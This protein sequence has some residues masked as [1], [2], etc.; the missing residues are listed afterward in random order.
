MVFKKIISF[1]LTAALTAVLAFNMKANDDLGS[2]QEYKWHISGRV[3]DEKGEPL[4]GT[5]VSIL[6]TTI[7]VG[8]NSEGYFDLKT[9]LSG[10]V[11]L[12]VQFI[13]YKTKEKKVVVGSNKSVKIAL[14]PSEN[15][16]DQVV[17]TGVRR[18]RPLKETPVLTR[19]ISEVDIKKIAPQNFETLLQYEL[20][21]LQISYNSMSQ[22]PEINYKGMG[23]DYIVFLVDGE[24]VSGEGAARNVDFSRFNVD[25]IERIEVVQGAASTLYDSN[26]LGGVVNIITKDANRPVTAVIS[27]RYAGNNGEKYSVCAGSKKSDFSTYTTFGY[28]HRGNYEIGDKEGQKHIVIH[29]DGTQEEKQ[30][31]AYSTKI[32]GYDIFDASQK[33]RYNV[34]EKLLT[35]VKGSVYRNKR[36]VRDGKRFYNVYWN[37]ALSAKVGYMFNKKNKIDYT[38]VY[39]SYDKVQNYTKINK[40][41]KNYRNRRGTSRLNYS[42]QFGKHAVSAG[43]EFKY[44]SLKHYMTDSSKCRMKHFDVF[45]Q[46]EF[47]INKDLKLVAG[48]RG[49]KARGYSLHFTPK[50]S[51]KYTLKDVT[52]RAGYAEGYRIPSLKELYTRYDMGGLGMFTI[53][54]NKNLK[55]EKSS[56]YTFSTEYSKG[57][58]NVS[59]SV[60]RNNFRRKIELVQ[61]TG[62]DATDGTSDNASEGSSENNL[63][64]SSQVGTHEK[65]QNGDLVYVNTNNARSTGFET[66]L[67][68]K[69]K[70]GFSLMGSYAYVNDHSEYN[71]KNVSYVRPHSVTFSTTYARDVHKTNLSLTLNG[72]WSSSL[73]TYG[74]NEDKSMTMYKYDSRTMCS[75]NLTARFPRGITAGF[76]IDNLLDY[77]D[78]SS[79]APLQV[80]TKGRTYVATLSIN[81]ADLFNL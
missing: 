32:Y 27:G 19:V 66:I 49:D 58:F 35:E 62:S 44:E 67:R 45:T 14:S 30:E 68:Y 47:L 3:V 18:E 21:G 15:F 29:P 57:L 79:S 31:E 1:T 65:P 54:G 81:I 12:A 53:F 28:R 36:A 78:K 9:R 50:L 16:I 71:G 73:K 11:T 20:P 51:L 43:A 59:V 2:E 70:S 60:Y 26:A 76:I 46:D 34:T 23:G 39:D 5:S 52:F 17:V 42:G 56:Q 8:T 24:R 80:P 7:G 33:F 13:G 75:L 6:G 48:I 37:Y 10:E 63:D 55:P 74:F 25:N 40:K 72:M 22:A 41:T 77:R 69:T 61:Y 64:S 38:H 4:A